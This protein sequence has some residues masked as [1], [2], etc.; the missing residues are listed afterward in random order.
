MTAISGQV[1]IDKCLA[2]FRPL[3][4]HN[5]SLTLL[6]KLLLGTTLLRKIADQALL[7]FLHAKCD[8]CFVSCQPTLLLGRR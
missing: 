2:T 6:R 5:H 1:R 4:N 7:D 8:C 3:K